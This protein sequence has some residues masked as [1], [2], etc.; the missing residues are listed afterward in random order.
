MQWSGFESRI[1]NSADLPKYNTSLHLY[2]YCANLVML[3]QVSL[4]EL[5]DEIVYK[6]RIS[7]RVQNR[8]YCLRKSN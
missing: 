1:S 6:E 8:R 5:S 7:I 4:L 3:T 2:E